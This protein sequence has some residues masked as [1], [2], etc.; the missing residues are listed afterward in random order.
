[1]T[2]ERLDEIEA[3]LDALEGGFLLERAHNWRVFEENAED[4]VRALIRYVR[5]LEAAARWRKPEEWTND[6]YPKRIEVWDGIFVTIL[7]MEHRADFPRH[8]YDAWRPLPAPPVD[9]VA[10]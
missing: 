7:N 6:V 9:E 2:I 1:M 8:S 10:S 5:E 3:R 4:D